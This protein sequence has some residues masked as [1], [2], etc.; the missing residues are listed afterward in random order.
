MTGCY[1]GRTECGNYVRHVLDAFFFEYT[2]YI[3]VGR[4]LRQLIRIS[5]FLTYCYC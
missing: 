5:Y 3:E 2:F 4:L 1:C